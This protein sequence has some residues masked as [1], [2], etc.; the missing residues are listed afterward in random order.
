MG[1]SNDH[2]GTMKKENSKSFLWL[3]LLFINLSPIYSFQNNIN[4]NYRSSGRIDNPHVLFAET[5]DDKKPQTLSP[6]DRVLLIGPGFLQLNIAKAAKAVGLLPMIIA[7]QKRLDSFKDFVNDDEITSLA[8]IG[9]PDEKRTING[10]VFCSEE[11]VFGP[12]LVKTILDWED[13]YVHMDGPAKVIACVPVSE[14]VNKDK[15]MGW[16]P[17]LNNDKKEK[18]IWSKFNKAFQD[19]PV[20]KASGNVIRVGSLLGGSIDGI[21]ELK[22]FGLDESIYKMSLENFRDLRERSFDRCRL[23]AQILEG[24]TV[25]K[26]RPP[27]QEELEKEIIKKSEHLEVFRSTGAYPETD[28]T[29]RHTAAQAVV[30]AL[31]RPNRGQFTVQEEGMRSIPKEFT[32]LSKCVAEIPTESDWDELFANPGPASWPHP[33]DFDPSKFNWD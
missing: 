15:S 4:K 10:V 9:L 22:D 1:K 3:F 8:D 2:S 30:Q 27:N 13:M 6:G 14:K 20:S 7:P 5:P 17:I 11:A 31:L 26:I 12:G 21:P 16:M 28:R 25:N 24:D 33:K 29:C 32:V 23:G 18:E 19:H